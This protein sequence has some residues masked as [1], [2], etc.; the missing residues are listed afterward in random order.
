ML[1]LFPNG[2]FL[3][4]I[5]GKI[6]VLDISPCPSHYNQRSNTVDIMRVSGSSK[7]SKVAGAIA[8]VLR[9]E[10][11]VVLQAIGAS[12]VNQT[13]KAIALARSYLQEESIEI[14]FIPEFVDVEIDDSVRTAI[15]FSVERR[16]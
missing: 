14:N 3:P 6:D 5:G 11:N 12:A 16:S 2:G 7:T 1:I 15:K 13:V 8:G 4:V 9:E 10:G